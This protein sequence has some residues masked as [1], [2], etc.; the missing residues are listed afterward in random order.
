MGLPI[1][2]GKWGIPC[3]GPEKQSAQLEAS[4]EFAKNF[5]LKHG[6]PTGTATATGSIDEARVAISRY[7]VVLKFDGL[8]A[9]KG[10]VIL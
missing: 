5:M 1:A 10:V 8:A 9:G 7:P 3:W 6:I 2:A 4:K